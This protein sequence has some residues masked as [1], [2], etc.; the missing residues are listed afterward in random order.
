MKTFVSLLS[1]FLCLALF[2]PDVHSQKLLKQFENKVKRRRDRKIDQTM[3]KVLD[4]VEESI[5]SSTPQKG[6]QASEA[7]PVEAPATPQSYPVHEGTPQP[8]TPKN[9]DMDLSGLLGGAKE[10]EPLPE[11]NFSQ[12]SRPAQGVIGKGPFGLASGMIVLES[13]TT[14]KMFQMQQLDT[15]YFDQYGQRQARYQHQNQRITGFGMNNSEKSHTLSLMLGDS[16]YSIDMLKKEG[17]V[18]LNPASEM[19]HGMSEQEMED[20]A[21]GIAEGFEPMITYLG[22]DV[23]LGKNCE[24]YDAKRYN[25]EGKLMAH[26][27]TWMRKGIVYKS[28]AR[29]MGIEMI[30][31]AKLVKEGASVSVKHFEKREDIVYRSLDIYQYQKN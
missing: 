16:I 4:K 28:I 31:E 9:S 3:D 25:E 26:A 14:N 17:S 24:V 11:G 27:R 6:E 19:Y 10:M 13:Q 18:M 21:Q 7:K 22:T 1:L 20:F 12:G 29:T 8:N 23:V 15:L 5:E 2:I 30:Q